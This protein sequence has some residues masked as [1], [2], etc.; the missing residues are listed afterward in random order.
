MSIS[1]DTLRRLSALRLA[2]EA[3]AEVLSILAD[4]QS[5]DEVRKSK[6]RARKRTVRG[7]S[8]ENPGIVQGNGEEIPADPPPAASPLVPPPTT[9]PYNPPNTTPIHTSAE[10]RERELDFKKRL[11]AVYAAS[12][13]V[14][15]PDGGHVAIWLARGYT[16]EICLAVVAEGLKSRGRFVPPKYFDQPIA[17]AHVAPVGQ[18]RPTAGRDK[19][20]LVSASPEERTAALSRVGQ[21]YLPGDDPLFPGA[22]ERYRDEHGKYPPRDKN[23]GW[24]FP[25]RYFAT[26]EAAA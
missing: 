18:V 22:S 13:V 10:A 12:G 4:M 25:E 5:A 17:D 26:S 11:M 3:M 8:T 16:P 1:A 21:R 14:G 9:P 6:D 7:H 24:Y 23:G 19:P 15:F 2:P 20:I